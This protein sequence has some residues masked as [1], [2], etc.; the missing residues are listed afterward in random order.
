MSGPAWLCLGTPAR[1]EPIAGFGLL[2]SGFRMKYAPGHAGRKDGI[3]RAEGFS[4][5]RYQIEFAPR[6]IPANSS[7]I[8]T[9]V[10]TIVR[11]VSLVGPDRM[12]VT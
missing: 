8:A 3:L 9:A 11:E 7:P 4:G 1:P 5:H 10:T 2:A 6:Y 12:A